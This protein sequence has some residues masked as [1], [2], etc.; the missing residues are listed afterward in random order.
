MLR[1]WPVRRKLPPNQSP[2]LGSEPVTFTLKVA[3]F[4][5]KMLNSLEDMG[6]WISP[7]TPTA[8]R[9]KRK[10]W[11]AIQ[12]FQN[13]TLDDQNGA[14]YQIW[15][16]KVQKISS[17]QNLDTQTIQIC[18]PSHSPNHVVWRIK[19]TYTMAPSVRLS[20]RDLRSVLSVSNTPHVTCS[21]ESSKQSPAVRFHMAYRRLPSCINSA[22]Q[23]IIDSS[24]SSSVPKKERK[25][26]VRG[27]QMS[28]QPY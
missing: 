7:L 10:I 20:A 21:M 3:D 22:L 15:L 24:T 1:M 19:T 28:A 26:E 8:V 23:F 16:Q 6:M 11:I 5:C 14:P 13:I 2:F 17:T 9:K 4:S 12:S 27:I 25:K 18:H